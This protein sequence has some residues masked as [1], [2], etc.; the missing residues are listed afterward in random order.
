MNNPTNPF[1]FN[2]HSYDNTHLWILGTFK[3]I[4]TP[5]PLGFFQAGWMWLGHL[6]DW[7][8]VPSAKCLASPWFSMFFLCSLYP[9]SDYPNGP[10]FFVAEKRAIFHAWHQEWVRKNTSASRTRSDH[11]GPNLRFRTT[12]WEV[13]L[14]QQASP[15]VLHEILYMA[16]PIFW[17]QTS[18]NMEVSQ[19]RGTPVH[20]AYLNGIFYQKPSIWGY[21]HGH[22][23]PLFSPTVKLAW[24]SRRLWGALRRA[25]TNGRRQRGMKRAWSIKLRM[26]P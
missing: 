21:P 18:T 9:K 15:R 25:F 12:E 11:L 2:E 5:D 17:L 26:R 4:P 14:N 6:D 23:K 19:N 1:I 7:C 8:P 24:L 13:L 20:H 10:T 3:M 16:H 22:G